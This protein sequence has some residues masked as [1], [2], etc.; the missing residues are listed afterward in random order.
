VTGLS[1]SKPSQLRLFTA[2]RV[3]KAS[4]LNS[5]E[6]ILFAWTL[7][8]VIAGYGSHSF[9]AGAGDRYVGEQVLT[10]PGYEYYPQ[11][12]TEP[13]E[14]T[15][16]LESNYPGFHT[17]RPKGGSYATPFNWSAPDGNSQRFRFRDRPVPVAPQVEQPAPRFRPDRLTGR[18]P[19]SWGREDGRWPEGSIGPPPVFRPLKN[20]PSNRGAAEQQFKHPGETYSPPGGRTGY[21]SGSGGYRPL[22]GR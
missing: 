2:S 22:P 7:I 13:A 18:S 17:Q 19:Y 4:W 20:E 16:R 9:A 21:E 10:P 15:D 1:E 11:Y 3:V 5:A 8:V 14:Y 12:P 6:A